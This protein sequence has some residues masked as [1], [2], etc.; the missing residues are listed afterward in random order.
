MVLCTN[1]ETAKTRKFGGGGAS[2]P[3]FFGVIVSRV[4]PHLQI[5]LWE[6]ASA[7]VE[8][9]RKKTFSNFLV[10]LSESLPLRGKPGNQTP[11]CDCDLLIC[12]RLE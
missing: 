1:G 10:L 2:P 4:N 6:R 11:L 5:V 12:P 3:G 8:G 7:V 9:N